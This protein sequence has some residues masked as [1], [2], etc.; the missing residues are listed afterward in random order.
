MRLG[1]VQHQLISV[2]IGVVLEKSGKTLPHVQPRQLEE[3]NDEDDDMQEEQPEEVQIMKEIAS[4]DKI[5]VWGHEF[6]PLDA[7]DPYSK[8]IEEWM[9]FAT[10]VSIKFSAL[11]VLNSF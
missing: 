6:V 9:S 10:A 4:F 5:A 1:A 8:G 7:E 2:F 3:G 11:T